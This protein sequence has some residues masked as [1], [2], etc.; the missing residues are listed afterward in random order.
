MVAYIYFEGL[1]VH[2]QNTCMEMSS[3]NKGVWFRVKT[4]NELNVLQMIL[5][6]NSVSKFNMTDSFI[7]LQNIHNL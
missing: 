7:I 1:G 4:Y 5:Q 6:S 3:L 2:E